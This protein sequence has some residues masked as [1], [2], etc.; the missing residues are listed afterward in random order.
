MEVCFSQ[1]YIICSFVVFSDTTF[2]QQS[3]KTI[4]FD[5]YHCYA[6]TFYSQYPY[7]EL[8][9]LYSFILAPYTPVKVHSLL[10]FIGLGLFSYFNFV[11]Y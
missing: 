11:L 8:S 7:S 9:K 10:L 4:K 2:L 5:L 3:N 6:L 1:K